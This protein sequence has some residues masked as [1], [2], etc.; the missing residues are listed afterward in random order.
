MYTYMIVD[1]DV[2]PSDEL[3]DASI[4]TMRHLFHEEGY[5]DFTIIKNHEGIIK[6]EADAHRW[7]DLEEI[8]MRIGGDD[9]AWVPISYI[10][11]DARWKDFDGWLD[12]DLDEF[13]GDLDEFI[14]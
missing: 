6:I 9:W 12:D 11:A 1:G 7:Q 10:Q 13:D 2:K 4:E 5:R 3:I 8:G 14:K